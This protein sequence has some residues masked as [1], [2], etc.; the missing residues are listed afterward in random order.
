VR[1]RPGGIQAT[2]GEGGNDEAVIPLNDPRTASRLSGIMGGGSTEIVL[3]LKGELMDFIEAQ[4]IE[5]GRLGLSVQG[6]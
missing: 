4:L 2:I 6:V 3:S 5:R 1:A